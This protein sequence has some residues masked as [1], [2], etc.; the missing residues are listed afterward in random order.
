MV[1]SVRSSSRS[2]S[3]FVIVV[4]Q[5]IV[6]LSQM[7]KKLLQQ[8]L[9]GCGQF[10]PP[11]PK[12]VILLIAYDLSL[13]THQQCTF[14]VNVLCSVLTLYVTL[15]GGNLIW[16][17][18]SPSLWVVHWISQLF[19]IFTGSRLCQGKLFS[20]QP[21]HL[22]SVFFSDISWISHL[23]IRLAS[24]WLPFWNLYYFSFSVEKNP[25][26]WRHTPTPPH[27]SVRL[28]MD[29]LITLADLL[30]LD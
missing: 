23:G 19:L 5:A 3:S 1:K 14:S 8:I 9:E 30:I 13:S 18:I 29:F 10:S 11:L 28:S 2:T 26:P 25:A 17:P 22:D 16:L 4:T 7:N 12:S 6:G 20:L 21:F 27:P 24:L 15:G